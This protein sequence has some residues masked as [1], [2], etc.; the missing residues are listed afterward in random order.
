MQLKTKKKKNRSDPSWVTAQFSDELSLLGRL[1]SLKIKKQ[2]GKM[3][4]DEIV[5]SD[6]QLDRPMF[7]E[8]PSD[9]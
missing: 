3:H 9:G 2:R 5:R 1:C 4:T 7:M 8:A 6:S